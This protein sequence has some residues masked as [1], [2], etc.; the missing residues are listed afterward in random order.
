MRWRLV[1]ETEQHSG[2]HLSQ[3]HKERYSLSLVNRLAKLDHYAKSIKSY[4]NKTKPHTPKIVVYTAISG[5]YDTLKLPEIIDERFDYIVFTDTPVQDT[6]VF[7]V[8]SLNAPTKDKTKVARYAKTHPHQLLKEYD[9][10]IWID[11]NIMILGDIYPIVEDFITSKQPLGVIP[12][13]IRKTVYEEYLACVKRSKDD[14]DVMLRQ[15]EKYRKEGFDG[16]GL[17]ESGFML[18]DLRQKP[19]SLFLDTWWDEIQQ[20]SKRDQLSLPYALSKHPLKTYKA[21]H[22]PN[23]IRDHPCFVLVSHSHE[24]NLLNTLYDRL[25]F[26]IKPL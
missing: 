17:I 10:A 3:L 7:K 25:A 12:H 15:L 21:T 14:K 19:I 23:N 26:N 6:G 24:Q 20:S 2:T 1:I 16:S 22:P 9:I 13:P 8:R 4:K 5:G 11:A 18:F